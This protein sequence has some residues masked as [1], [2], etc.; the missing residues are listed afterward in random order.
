MKSYKKSIKSLQ[1]FIVFGTGHEEGATFENIDS[2][3]QKVDTILSNEQDSPL[4]SIIVNAVSQLDF[5]K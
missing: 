2:Y 5:S 3:V 1:N 4:R